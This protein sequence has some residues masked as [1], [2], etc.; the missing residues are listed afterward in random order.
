MVLNGG[1]LITINARCHCYYCTLTLLENFIFRKKRKKKVF[2]D[3]RRSPAKMNSISTLSLRVLPNRN[4]QITAFF[5]TTSSAQS[6]IKRTHT[7]KPFYHIKKTAKHPDE[8]LT[9]ENKSFVEDMIKK[10]YASNP[11][12]SYVRPEIETSEPGIISGSLLRPELQPWQRGGWDEYSERTKRTGLLARKIGVVPM[13][14]A[15]GKRVAATM[16]QVII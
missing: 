7:H 10:S 12:D 9:Y 14:F 6:R 11:L 15:N 13:W 16:L 8:P 3:L 2:K 5:H 4:I 1:N